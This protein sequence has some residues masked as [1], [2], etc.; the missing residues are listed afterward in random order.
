ML[1]DHE[2]IEANLWRDMKSRL[3]IET[4]SLGRPIS[5]RVSLWRMSR[6]N[7]EP[8]GRRLNADEKQRVPHASRPMSGLAQ[9]LILTNRQSVDNCIE[10]SDR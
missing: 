7:L 9:A 4:E 2:R 6:A 3:R 5:G 8:C 10:R 1:S